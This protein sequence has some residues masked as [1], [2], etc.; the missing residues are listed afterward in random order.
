MTALEACDGPH[1]RAGELDE[2]VVE[3]GKIWPLVAEG[4][5]QAVFTGHETAWLF[6]S[7]KVFLHFK[8]VTP[9]EHFEKK[10]F[11][12]YRVRTLIGAPG[13]G[14]RFKLKPRSDL[15]LMLCRVLDLK[16]RPDRISLRDLKHC[17]LG[18][19]TRTVKADFK[20]KELPDFLR[21]SVVDEVLGKETGQ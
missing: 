13:P 8:I 7:C 15:F 6:K 21:Y 11:R 14:G 19:S 3:H 20:Q 10:L 12:A 18:I 5:Y 9:G 16:A 4:M 2:V 1:L 17:V